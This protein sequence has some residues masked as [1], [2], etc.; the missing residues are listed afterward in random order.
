MQSKKIGDQSDIYFDRGSY[1]ILNRIFPSAGQKVT[2]SRPSIFR[3]RTVAP[4]VAALETLCSINMAEIM[5]RGLFMKV[6]GAEMS[7]CGRKMKIY[8]HVVCF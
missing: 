2:R 3:S 4:T 1:R 7:A 6:N 5:S 8:M